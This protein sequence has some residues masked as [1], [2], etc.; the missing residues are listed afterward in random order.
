MKPRLTIAAFILLSWLALWHFWPIDFIHF[1]SNRDLLIARDCYDLGRC[2]GHGPPTSFTGLYQGV[3]WNNAL[4]LMRWLGATPKAIGL[5]IAW[6]YALVFAASARWAQGRNPRALWLL[7]LAG[8]L[9]SMP[10]VLWS[11]TLFFPAMMLTTWLTLDWLERPRWPLALGLGLLWGVTLDLYLAGGP[12]LLATV[13]LGVRARKPLQALA[14]VVLALLVG[15]AVSPGAWLGTLT[16]I[17]EHPIRV[18]MVVLAFAAMLVVAVRMPRLD[19]VAVLALA[20]TGAWLVIGATRLFQSRYLMP[21]FPAL[22]LLIA[23]R[24]PAKRTWLVG[25]VALLISIAFFIPHPQRE[26]TYSNAEALAKAMEQHDIGWPQALAHAQGDFSRLLAPTTLIFLPHA[27]REWRG[28]DVAMDLHAT[29]RFHSV[30]SRMDVTH[31]ELCRLRTGQRDCGPLQLDP[32]PPGSIYPM[33]AAVYAAVIAQLPRD[34]TEL[35][36][37]VA[38]RAGPAERLQLLPQFAG[39]TKCPWHFA[40]GT[41]A[42]ELDENA[43]EV[44]LTRIFTPHVCPDGIATSDWLP[45]WRETPHDPHARPVPP[46]PPVKRMTQPILPHGVEA[47]FAR[48]ATLLAN[49]MHAPEPDIAVYRESARVSWPHQSPVELRSADAPPW[50]QVVDAGSDV[51]RTGAVQRALSQVFG[52]NPW[53]DADAQAQALRLERKPMWPHL[54][55]AGLGLLVVLLA[56]VRVATARRKPAAEAPH[57]PAP[58]R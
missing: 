15:V 19:A 32:T 35:A 47:K 1:D 51:T 6:L 56:G 18:A 10:V 38:V 33:A 26:L 13:A 23:Q 31:A 2:D 24:V 21:G 22:A 28:E 46:P 8:S 29:E 45:T 27:Q 42:L 49:E 11:P 43:T 54:T 48:L 20:G 17:P 7:L 5:G 3:L 40:D 34:V 58:R 25:A 30:P 14:I 55:L 53:Q 52:A 16:F 4:G 36:L 37:R 57:T 39:D 44:R 12:V 50:F 9:A 41:T